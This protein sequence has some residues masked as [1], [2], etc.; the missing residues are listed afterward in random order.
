MANGSSSLQKRTTRKWPNG[1]LRRLEKC[2]EP[3]PSPSG[4]KRRKFSEKNARGGWQSLFPSK[5]QQWPNEN[6]KAKG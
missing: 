4:V 3:Y 5:N 1:V 2:D 6:S